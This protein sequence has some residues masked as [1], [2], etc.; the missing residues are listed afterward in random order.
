VTAGGTEIKCLTAVGAYANDVN[1]FGDNIKIV[2][3]KSKVLID[4]CKEA[5]LEVNTTKSMY[6]CPCLFHWNARKVVT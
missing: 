2:K 4:A 3:K 5:D 1:L 6:L